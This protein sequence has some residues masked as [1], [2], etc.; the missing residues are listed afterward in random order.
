MCWLQCLLRKNHLNVLVFNLHIYFIFLF[1]QTEV[2]SGDMHCEFTQ[3]PILVTVEQ[4][5]CYVLPENGVLSLSVIR[6][7]NM[8]QPELVLTPSDS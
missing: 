8:Y 7:S 6:I 1:T 3:Q 2:L 4:Q 5:N